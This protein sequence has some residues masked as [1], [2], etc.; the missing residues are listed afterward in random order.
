MQK[1]MKTAKCKCTCYHSYKLE[2][3][4]PTCTLQMQ[5]VNTH[6]RLSANHADKQVMSHFRVREQHAFCS[7][8]SMMS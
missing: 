8:C 3:Y 1:T 7:Q 4:R 5:S 6:F 2:T